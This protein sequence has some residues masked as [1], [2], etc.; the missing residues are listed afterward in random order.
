LEVLQIIMLYIRLTNRLCEYMLELYHSTRKSKV[1][2]KLQELAQDLQVCNHSFPVSSS[3][4]TVHLFERVCIS[5]CIFLC[6]YLLKQSAQESAGASPGP[7]G[8]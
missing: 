7:P 1:P 6:V 4:T 2:K 8:V 3:I 5:M